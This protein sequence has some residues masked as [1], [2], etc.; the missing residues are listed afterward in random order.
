MVQV[1]SMLCS[2]PGTTWIGTSGDR[3]LE[4]LLGDA[5]APSRDPAAACQGDGDGAQQGDAV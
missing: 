1:T 3:D 4:Q 5:E 2:S